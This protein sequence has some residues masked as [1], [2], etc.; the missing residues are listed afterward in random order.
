MVSRPDR[1]SCRETRYEPPAGELNAQEAASRTFATV[2]VAT[3]ESSIAY[4]VPRREHAQAAPLHVQ[5]AALVFAHDHVGVLILGDHVRELL[6]ELG[7]RVED[8]EDLHAERVVEAEA[9]EKV[10]TRS[11]GTE[12]EAATSDHDAFVELDRNDLHH[13]DSSLAG[14]RGVWFEGRTGVLEGATRDASASSSRV[15]VVCGV[16]RVARTLGPAAVRCGA[17]VCEDDRRAAMRR[18]NPEY[19]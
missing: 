19:D 17:V 18:S 15:L 16:Q 10:A 12:R 6:R 3:A 1:S 8:R 11:E 7:H 4:S 2:S 13:D 9:P 5:E 14:G